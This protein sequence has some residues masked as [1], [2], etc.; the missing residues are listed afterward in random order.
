MNTQ[1]EYKGEVSKKENEINVLKQSFV[2]DSLRIAFTELGDIHY[3]FG[4]V[5]NAVFSYMKAYDYANVSEDQ[6]NIAIKICQSCLEAQN[7]QALNKYM[8]EAK[9]KD[10]GKDEA[11]SNLL[12]LFPAMTQVV[13]GNYTKAVD[14]L[15]EVS[16]NENSEINSVCTIQDVAF[17]TT[18]FALNNLSRA[19]LKDKVI[20]S[21]KF[22]SH[23]ESVPELAEIIEH[24]L[25]GRYDEFNKCLLAIGEHLQFDTILGSKLG[26]TLTQIKRKAII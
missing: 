22:K 25:N 12:S 9:N 14:Y 26:K 20:A 19:E 23:T 21:S 5:T 16:A 24:Y 13:Q 2:K 7:F 3:K 4:S 6:F 1:H 17:Y 8:N 18:I 11:K 10:Q 15:V